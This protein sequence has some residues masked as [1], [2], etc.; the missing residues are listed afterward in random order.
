MIATKMYRAAFVV[1]NKSERLFQP[2]TSM[3][4]RCCGDEGCSRAES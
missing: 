2:D 3:D 1:D 4:A